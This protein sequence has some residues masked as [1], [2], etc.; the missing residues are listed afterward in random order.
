VGRPRAG[1][2]AD[3]AAAAARPQRPLPLRQRTQVQEVLRASAV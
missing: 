1:A 3:P 2:C